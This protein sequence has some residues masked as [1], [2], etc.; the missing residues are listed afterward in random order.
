[1]S[2]LKIPAY[3]VLSISILLSLSSCNNKEEADLSKSFDSLSD[4]IAK[5]SAMMNDTA[6]FD[7]ALQ[8]FAGNYKAITNWGDYDKSTRTSFRKAV[9]G[10]YIIVP[11]TKQQAERIKNSEFTDTSLVY[12]GMKNN[13]FVFVVN[14]GGSRIEK[15]DRNK[16]GLLL[17]KV[18]DIEDA[19]KLYL[20]KKSTDFMHKERKL[21]EFTI[22][23]EL[24]D[25]VNVDIN[26]EVFKNKFS[27][28]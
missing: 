21:T 7:N 20:E 28:E 3:L 26:E 10:K 12:F 9:T 6:D 2:K 17:M 8:S 16:N 5:D 1:L 15:L 14:K 23:A 13:I 27:L 25:A 4:K 24:I 19:L 22:T 11:I 18:R